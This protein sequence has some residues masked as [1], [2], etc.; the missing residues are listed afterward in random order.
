MEL[1]QMCFGNPT[2]AF[3]MLPYQDALVREILREIERVYWNKYQTEFDLYCGDTLPGIELRPYYW[4]DDEDKAELP[5][6]KFG[7]Q[8]IRWYK[9][10]MRGSTCTL[11]WSADQWVAWFDAALAHIHSL[12]T[13]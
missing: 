10:P 11:D 12:D 4:G 1:G 7:E 8:E 2:G 13:R 6:L 5:N 3:E 9:H